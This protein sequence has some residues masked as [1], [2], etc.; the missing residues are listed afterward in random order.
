MTDSPSN[1]ATNDYPRPNQRWQAGQDDGC[2]SPQ[3]SVRGRRGVFISCVLLATLGLLLIGLARPWRNAVLKPGP[4]SAAH[5]QALSDVAESKQCASCH[6]AAEADPIAWMMIAAGNIRSLGDGQATRCLKC[7]EQSLDKQW[8]RFAH[9]V[10][11]DALAKLTAAHSASAN[12]DR[13]GGERTLSSLVAS[14]NTQQLACSTCHREHHGHQMNLGQLTDQQCQMCHV[15]Q[16]ASFEHGHPEFR[17]TLP[18]RRSPIAFDHVAH[19]QKHFPTKQQAFSCNQCHADDA[20][21]DVK[22]LTGFGR[23]CAQCHTKPIEA[24]GLDGLAIFSLPTLDVTKLADAGFAVGDW[25]AAAQ[26]DFDGMI[27]P[28]V[29]LLLAADDQANLALERLGPDFDFSQASPDDYASISILA[30]SYKRLLNELANDSPAALRERLNNVARTASDSARLELVLRQLPPGL[31]RE[32]RR[33]WLPKLEQELAIHT[34]DRIRSAHEFSAIFPLVRTDTA[35]S[36]LLI[37]NPLAK[38]RPAPAAA[39]ATVP[40]ITWWSKSDQP[41]PAAVSASDTVP[42]PQPSVSNAP[43][44]DGNSELLAENPLHK[45]V[46]MPPDEPPPEPMVEVPPPL[47]EAQPM[48]EAVESPAVVETPS[49][50]QAAPSD[51]VE[52]VSSGSWY[53]DDATLSVRYRPHG[54]GDELLALLLDISAQATPSQAPQH[55]LLPALLR[56]SSLKSCT[57]CHSIDVTESHYGIQWRATYRDPSRRQFTEFSHR[58]HLVQPQLADCTKCHVLNATSTVLTNYNTTEPRPV[59][60][61]FQPITKSKC[62]TCHTQ[63]EAGSRCTLC[64]SY[65]VGALRGTGK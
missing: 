40:G 65:H 63:A 46:P 33:R 17:H 62:V 2:P 58:P 27:P 31:F 7:H 41:P 15:Q 3:L 30:W 25:P 20:R 16:F 39:S 36:E 53:L 56:E 57:S 59:A 19:Q 52:L 9:N 34:Q 38:S 43:P 22:R 13:H 45:T 26:G 55:G 64:H 10:S 37:E 1:A 5:A 42:L 51:P 49:A 48:S 29:R 28:V 6:D 50:E 32:A 8:A 44:S 23:S 24:A 12:P 47:A 54:H 61:D 35:T 21:R 14:P 60:H 11:P 4:L 18:T